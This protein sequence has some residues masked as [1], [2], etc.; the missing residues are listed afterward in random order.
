MTLTQEQIKKLAWNLAKIQTNDTKLEWDIN[1]ILTYI[2]LLEEV[3]TTWVIPTVSVTK[4][5]N[6]L[7]EDAEIE[8]EISRE[9]LL[10]CSNQK[11]ISDQI[12]VASIMK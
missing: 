9:D 2:D 7:R 1:E 3:D 4:K 8:K 10:N 12:A 5:E 11:I 6:I